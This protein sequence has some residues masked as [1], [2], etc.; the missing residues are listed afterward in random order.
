MSKTLLLLRL[1]ALL[2]L[3]TVSGALAEMSIAITEPADGSFVAPCTDVLFKFDPQVTDETIRDIRIYYNGRIRGTV[4]REPWEYEWRDILRGRY[5]VQALLRVVDGSEAWSETVTIRAGS[6]SNGEKLVNGSFQCGTTSNWTFN[7]H[8]GAI[9]SMQ[10]YDDGLFDDDYYLAIEI[11]NGGTAEWHIQLNQTM[12]TDS[13][14]VY[15]IFFLADAEDT[16]T[17]YW[18]MQENQDPW[19]S[20]VWEPLEIDGYDEYGPLKF[21]AIKP[22]R[23]TSFA[24]T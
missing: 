14:H 21:V 10:L 2:S 20:Q 8:E 15:E 12:P 22:I 4:R 5:E 16:K 1:I 18:G 3:T 13:G 11:E 9:A 19:A 24:S 6:V 7:A 17:I 23:P